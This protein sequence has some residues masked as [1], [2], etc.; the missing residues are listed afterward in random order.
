[1]VKWFSIDSE[2]RDVVGRCVHALA[3]GSCP[4]TPTIDRRINL[5]TDKPAT[6]R[7]KFAPHALAPLSLNLN[8]IKQMVIRLRLGFF[9]PDKIER[10]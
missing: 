7:T 3:F 10:A 6:I 8:R 2:S 4:Y 1:M 5:S 9:L